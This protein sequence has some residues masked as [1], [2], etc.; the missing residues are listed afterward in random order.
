MKKTIPILFLMISNVLVSQ[1]TITK[2]LGDFKKIKVYNGISL[3]LIKSNEQ[4]LQIKGEKGAKVKVKNTNGTLKISLKF[5]EISASGK[6]EIKLFHKK[7][8]LTID[9]NEG[10]TISGKEIK[11]KFLEVKAQEGAFVNLNIQTTHLKVKSSSGGVVKLIGSTKN[12]DIYLDLY[13]VYQGYGLNVVDYTKINV[14]TGAK[15]EVKAGETLDVKVSFGGSVF[16]KGNPD[17][18]KDKK[19]AGGIIKQMN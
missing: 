8:I 14:G 3:E 4:K 7:D 18:I 5:P 6:V 19:V 1:T 2:R 15:A 11:Q 16:Y 12:Q 10:A 9:G 17:V 13:G